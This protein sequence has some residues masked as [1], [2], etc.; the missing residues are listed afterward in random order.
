[1]S[2]AFLRGARTNFFYC[3]LDSDTNPDTFAAR[4]RI[5]G[6]YHARDIHEFPGGQCGFHALKTC[7]CGKCGEEV[8]CQ[9]EDYHTKNPLK[10]PFHSLAYE[11]ECD[12]RAAQSSEIIHKE[13]GR[14]HSNYPEASHNVL[15]RFRSK[16]TNKQCIHYMVTTNLGL[17][18]AN[19]SYLY[20]KKGA[21]YHWI[22]D[23][24]SRLRLPVLDGMQ[25]ALLRANQKRHQNLAKKQSE[26]GK[27][28]RTR[29][30]KARAQEHEERKSWSRQ[31]S[32]AHTYGSESDNVEDEENSNAPTTSARNTNRTRVRR[33]RPQVC[34]ANDGSSDDESGGSTSRV[35]TCG[36]ARATHQRS[37]PLNPRNL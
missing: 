27:D 36:S 25:E 7:T 21:S 12:S 31:Q 1:M 19:M 15:I 24:F 5:L 16:D 3:L 37:C 17:L 13:L 33:N 22:L 10:C 4:M 8:L 18:Q 26:E 29:W 35:C 20:E 9:G 28:A 14:G 34:F 2:K 6:K 11:I 32:I 23:L 30:K